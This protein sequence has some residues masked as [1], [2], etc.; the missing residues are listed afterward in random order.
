[1]AVAAVLTVTGVAAFSR[2]GSS[3]GAPLALCGRHPAAVGAPREL[4]AGYPLP[5]HTVI[6]RVQRVRGVVVV[7]GI[8]PLGIRDAGR[9]LITELPGAGYR[10]G[11]GDSEADEAETDFIGHGAVGRVKVHTIP[12]CARATHLVVA[13]VQSSR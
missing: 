7:Q 12:G 6:T 3:E 8:E 2:Q 1:V 11:R 5:K 10:I 9:F 13:L 4:P